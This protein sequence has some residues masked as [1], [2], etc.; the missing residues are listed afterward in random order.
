MKYRRMK[1]MEDGNKMWAK[2]CEINNFEY[3]Q[4]LIYTKTILKICNSIYTT[5]FL[6]WS[7]KKQSSK[8][9]K[10]KQNKKQTKK[11]PTTTN[12]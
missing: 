5:W 11:T 1:I 2:I 10:Q 9:Q 8:K 12:S 4:K 3:L 6:T 7:S